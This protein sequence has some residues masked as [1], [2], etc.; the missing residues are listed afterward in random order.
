MEYPAEGL[1]E[2]NESKAYFSHGADCNYLKLQGMDFMEKKIIMKL[3]WDEMYIFYDKNSSSL[4]SQRC[5]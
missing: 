3:L 2:P 4:S 1:T 5:I